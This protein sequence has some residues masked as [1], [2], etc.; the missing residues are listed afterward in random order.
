MNQ[1]LRIFFRASRRNIKRSRQ[2]LGVALLTLMMSLSAMAQ[3]SMTSSATSWSGEYTVTGNVT[4]DSEVRLTGDATVNLAEGATLNINGRINCS[5]GTYHAL[6]INGSGTMN[7]TGSYD[8]VGIIRYFSKATIN[9]GTVNIT[10]NA[11]IYGYAFGSDGSNN[12][13]VELNG[14]S[15]YSTVP[16]Q[17]SA[18]FYGTNIVL[19]GGTL[20]TKNGLSICDRI[21]S[22]ADGYIYE[23]KATEKL[24]AGTLTS[25]EE[26]EILGHEFAR[27]LDA[28]TVKVV[29]VEGV[30]VTADCRAAKEGQTIN[31]TAK[32]TVA[33]YFIG[34]KYNDGTDHELELDSDGKCSFEMRETNVTIS[35]TKT[36]AFVEGDGT[37]DNPFLIKD[38]N[39]W[40]DFLNLI[41]SK[42]TYEVNKDKHYKLDNDV[43]TTK[44]VGTLDYPFCG[45][46]DG[47]GNTLTVD[48]SPTS[49][50]CAPF[51]YVCGTSS[52]PVL[53]KNLHIAGTIKT[54]KAYAAGIVGMVMENGYLTIENCR[55]SVAIENK[56]NGNGYY[57]GFV[58]LGEADANISIKGCV[59]DGSIIADKSGQCAGFF[60]S[61]Q[62]NDVKVTI[63]NCLFAPTSIK[64]KNYNNKTFARGS[65][66]VTITKC[67]Y[68]KTLGTAQGKKAYEVSSSPELL[69]S[70]TGDGIVKTYG[71]YGL[72]FNK[73]YY[74]AKIPLSDSETEGVSYLTKN[75][76]GKTVPVVFKREFSAGKASTICL[77]FAMDKVSGGKVYSFAGITYDEKDGWVATMSEAEKD[78]NNVTSTKAN[79]PYVFM[80]DADGE[81]TFSGTTEKIPAAYD[82][83]ELSTVS[84]DWTFRGTYEQLK[85]GSNLD[86]HVYGF[87]SRDKEV[88]GVNVAA[89]E[90]VKAKDGAGVKP[91]RCYLTYKNGDEFAGARAV[92]RG[93]EE[94]LPQSITVKFVGANGET[95]A[96]ATL[97]TQTGEITT[98]DAWYTLSGTRL[99]GKPSQR[100]IYISNGRKVVLH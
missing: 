96:I 47:Q 98:D 76:Q 29:D 55:S 23:D 57:S 66:N 41:N 87:A 74:L 37:K 75:L 90:F 53:I 84:G 19:A 2:H 59:F 3:Q 73:K 27:N 14:G 28:Y 36:A 40:S 32:P 62:S 5:D 10:N 65:G 60:A 71:T 94:N 46:F 86:G 79:T 4:I 92:T 91:M 64:V 50:A 11:D 95:T 48:Y 18:H 70:S 89:G 39:D 100:G 38:E 12:R 97:N 82:A 7:V 85:Y 54:T 24:Y 93:I 20:C 8:G 88:D 9:G 15:L 99:P 78:G 72:G 34:A 52:A 16:A 13:V 80:P 68:T 30:T 22:I 21:I 43:S 67:Y 25:N 42:L 17:H 44:M 83:K 6:T 58:S 49:Q 35:G 51:S 33:G 77:P 61:K 1:L 45:T 56:Y 63:D 26:M 81:V 69:G 31:V